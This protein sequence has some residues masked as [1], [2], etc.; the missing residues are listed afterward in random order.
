MRDQ[1]LAVVSI[2][3]S[4]E[5]NVNAASRYDRRTPLQVA[6]STG[7]TDVIQL[8]VVNGAAV[9]Q[10]DIYGATALH[11][12]VVNGYLDAAEVSERNIDNTGI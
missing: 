2:L 11:L 6:A 12:T 1:L 3:L 10:T 7:N 4:H 9:H 8:L 5:A